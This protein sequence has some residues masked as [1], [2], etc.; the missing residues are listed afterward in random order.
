MSAS[1]QIDKTL[2]GLRPTVQN[3]QFYR[4]DFGGNLYLS[5]FLHSL[6]FSYN[7]LLATRYQLKL[8]LFTQ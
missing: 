3:F 8:L 1:L 4:R 5:K 2:N 6:S 7:S